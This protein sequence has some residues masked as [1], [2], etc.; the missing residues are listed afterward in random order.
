MPVCV[1]P[2]CA[3]SPGPA[4]VQLYSSHSVGW[5]LR[6]TWAGGSRAIVS[7]RVQSGESILLIFLEKGNDV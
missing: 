1:P 5:G 2:S 6:G 4:R 7:S 3:H